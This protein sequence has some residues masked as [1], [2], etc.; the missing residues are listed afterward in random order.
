MKILSQSTLAKAPG[1]VRLATH[2]GWVV[3][4]SDMGAGYVWRPGWAAFKPL[5]QAA[6]TRQ[7][8][9][10]KLVD[11]I[12]MNW[13]FASRC[14]LGSVVA[15]PD[16]GCVVCFKLG[17]KEVEASG[18]PFAKCQWGMAVA[19]L[20][21]DGSVVW[22]TRH[23]IHK[24]N[25]QVARYDAT[26]VQLIASTGIRWVLSPVSGIAVKKDRV[27]MGASGEKNFTPPDGTAC[28]FVGYSKEPS[29][30]TR[31]GYDTKAIA[32][33]SK[34]PYELG[35]DMLYASCLAPSGKPRGLWVAFV[36]DDRLRYN[37][38]APKMRD[39]T[40][41]PA[42]QLPDGGPASK[43]PRQAPAL[44]Q[45]PGYKKGVG[46]AVRVAGNI[47]VQI[48]DKPGTR[49]TVG[50]GAWPTADVA[51]GKPVVYYLSNGTLR[52]A[53]IDPEC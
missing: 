6:W 32:W 25:A 23:A 39:R 11:Q 44:F 2:G 34:P 1:L 43:E 3:A 45:I 24:G 31:I 16:G 22:Q 46:V 12:G 9:K 13:E 53:V 30:L 42:N 48:L 27:P 19:R 51:D 29:K 4:D 28:V 14:Y 52:K 26:N 49:V 50:P 37:F 7:G 36:P 40:K 15:L 10:V 47:A 8:P 17:V 38:C 20:A 35:D 41:W 21:A 18:V 5:F 33:S